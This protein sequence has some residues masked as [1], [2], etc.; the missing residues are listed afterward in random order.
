M[1]NKESILFSGGA[2]GTIIIPQYLSQT[3]PQLFSEIL[4]LASRTIPYCTGSCGNC[5]GACITG[6][7]AIVWLAVC[8]AVRRN[9]KNSHAAP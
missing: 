2:A 6:T 4:P 1:L 3:A 8:A 9:I 7:A 5:G